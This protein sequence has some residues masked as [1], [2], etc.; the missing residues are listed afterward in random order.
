MLTQPLKCT[1]SHRSV[2]PFFMLS[3][4]LWLRTINIGHKGHRVYFRRLLLTLPQL[5]SRQ[6]MKCQTNSFLFGISG[7]CAFI[8]CGIYGYYFN[9]TSLCV[10]CS[11]K[12]VYCSKTD[13][14]SSAELPAAGS[15]QRSQLIFVCFCKKSL[16]IYRA[17]QSNL[18][19]RFPDIVQAMK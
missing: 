9:D 19:C 17:S 15:F 6:S 3:Q 10:C 1:S 8:S 16:F 18:W 7:M 14:S 12:L 5:I 4:C 2:P 11:S 13:S